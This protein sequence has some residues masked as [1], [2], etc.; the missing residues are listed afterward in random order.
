MPMGDGMTILNG[1]DREDFTKKVAF[2]L[3]YEKVRK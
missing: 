1:M 2:E 3:K